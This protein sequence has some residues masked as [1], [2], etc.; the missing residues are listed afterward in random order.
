[1]KGSGGK[2]LKLENISPYV[3]YV[4][5]YVPL[6]TY[7]EKERV[8]YDHEFMYVKDG[9]VEMNYGGERFLL[10]RGDIFY[11]S[12]FV[13]NY[14][15]VRA[16]RGFKT[17]CIHFDWT[18]GEPEYDFRAE[19]FYM[20][21]VKDGEREKRLLARPDISPSDFNVPRLMRGAGAEA[22]ELFGSCYYAYINAAPYS[23]LKLKALFT[24]IT[25]ELA[26]LYSDGT[27]FIH[28][29]VAA[30][31]GY[32]Q[33]NYGRRVEVPE[34]AEKY[35]LSPKY[36]G[37][38]FKAATG[39]S[40]NEFTAETRLAAAKEMLVGSDM[41]VGEIAEK[42]GFG[43]LYYFSKCFKKHERATPSEF[44]RRSRKT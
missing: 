20:G 40:V 1:M 24:D 19:D 31:V 8:I 44:R 6:F 42:T 18:S 12:P 36:F 30:A 14:I 39:R 16:E 32:I 9:S 13:K 34:L 35:G 3:R 41:P 37:T 2:M 4:N 29:K 25:A 23:R 27:P 11:I 10:N 38:I 17:H 28:P 15:S 5:Y 7:T 26:R 22:G 33:K 21:A 43:S